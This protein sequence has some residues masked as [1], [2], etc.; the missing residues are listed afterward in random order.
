MK[1]AL[2]AICLVAIRS[3]RSTVRSSVLPLAHTVYTAIRHLCASAVT[4]DAASHLEDV[5]A[6]ADTTTRASAA[7]EHGAQPASVSRAGIFIRLVAALVLL[8]SVV[9]WLGF[10]WRSLHRPVGQYDF[11]SYYAAALA[12]RLHHGANI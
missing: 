2:A 11:S 9:S 1:L 5:T 3:S 7:A 8:V 4:R 12:L 10:L 6:V